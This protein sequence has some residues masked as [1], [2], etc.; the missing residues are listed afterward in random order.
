MASEGQHP[1][2]R[3]EGAETPGVVGRWKLAGLRPGKRSRFLYPGET[4]YSALFDYN[5]QPFFKSFLRIDVARDEVTIYCFGVAE[6][7]AD[8]TV[9]DHLRWAGGR[10]TDARAILGRAGN[11]EVV[12]EVDWYDDPS[13]VLHLEDGESG[14]RFAVLVSSDGDEWRGVGTIEYRPGEAW[15]PDHR[16]AR[17]RWIGLRREGEGGEKPTFAVGNVI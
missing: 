12:G 4:I 16:I 17:P 11:G 6:E 10:W 5:D 2:R 7:G 8:A 3:P 15:Q 13:L 9:E 14:K 1:V